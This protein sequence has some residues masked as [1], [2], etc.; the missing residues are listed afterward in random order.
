MYTTFEIDPEKHKSELKSIKKLYKNSFP[1]EEREPWY[2]LKRELKIAGTSK[3]P[4][5]KK[6]VIM[7]GIKNVEDPSKVLGFANIVYIIS[8]NFCFGSYL[9]IEPEDMNKGLGSK[10]VN[11]VKEYFI[12]LAKKFDA[13]KPIGFFYEI[14]KHDLS[15]Y[16]NKDR[17]QIFARYRFYNRLNQK[18]ID[19]PYFQPALRSWL[20]KV[21]MHLMFG[22]F[23]EK[24]YFSK[25]EILRIYTNIYAV[26]YHK[27]EKSLKRLFRR[28][29]VV[30][31]PNR[32]DL[33]SLDSIVQL[34]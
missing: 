27:S 15:R 16:N 9:A 12:E 25:E 24:K 20:P 29:N 6:F 14:D 32:I 3:L 13:E 8:S 1:P 21:P 23:E 33:I 31:L 28:L 5:N 19:V 7:L 10:F 26:L 2:L 34:K 22:P 11:E 4:Y 17:E 18:K 30:D